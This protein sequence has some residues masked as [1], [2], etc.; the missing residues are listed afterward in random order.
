MCPE[1]VSTAL[2]DPRVQDVRVETPPALLSHVLVQVGPG[3]PL[4]MPDAELFLCS[5]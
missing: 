1:E 5:S 3:G 4:V 2:P